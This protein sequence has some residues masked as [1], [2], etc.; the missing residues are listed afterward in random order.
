MVV[1]G[2]VV[3]ALDGELV[4]HAAARAVEPEALGVEPVADVGVVRVRDPCQHFGHGRIDAQLVRIVGH[5]V[6]ALHGARGVLVA[7]QAAL[8]F[9]RVDGAVADR[10][11]RRAPPLEVAEDEPLVFQDFGAHA[12]AV[13]VLDELRARG[14]GVVVEKVVGVEFRVAQVLK[15]VAVPVVGAAAGD[16]LHLRAGAAAVLRLSGARHHAKLTDRIGVVG[17]KG[18]AEARYHRVVDVDA[19]EFGVVGALAQ[20]VDTRVTRIAGI[21]GDARSRQRGQRDGGAA[22]LRKRVDLAHGDGSRDLRFGA[23]HRYGGSFHLHAFGGGAEFELHGLRQ[24]RADVELDSVDH[25]LAENRWLPPTA[26]RCRPEAQTERTR[27]RRL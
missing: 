18:K 21:D 14:A 5:D 12:A 22:Q 8:G 27:W 10:V 25:G 1:G 4:F 13:D 26:C 19:V 16:Q 24:F 20:P 6:V 9:G 11:L 17:G 3:V 2:D 7:E 15:Q 23:L